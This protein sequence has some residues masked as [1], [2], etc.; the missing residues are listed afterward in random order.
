MK[1]NK[2][3]KAQKGL[4]DVVVPEK[5]SGANVFSSALSM[6]GTGAAVGGPWGAAAGAAAGLVTGLI[7]KKKQEIYL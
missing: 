4:Q 3:Q 6:A 5:G 2:I 7:Q 1:K